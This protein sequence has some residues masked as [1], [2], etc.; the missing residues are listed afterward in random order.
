MATNPRGIVTPEAV[1]LD[2]ETAGIASRALARVIDALIQGAALLAL[3]LLIVVALPGS[4]GVV[5]AVIGV[6]AIVLG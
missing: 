3:I 5:V 6:A 4:A 1:V 2:F